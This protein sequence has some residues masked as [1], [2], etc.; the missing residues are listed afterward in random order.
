LNVDGAD[1]TEA[2]AE[3]SALIPGIRATLDAIPALAFALYP[4]GH[5]AFGNRA[6]LALTGMDRGADP[7]S[8]RTAVH[9]DDIDQG[10]DALRVGLSTQSSFR[11]R[12]RIRSA[13]GRYR[14]Y[15]S[16]ASPYLDAD[17][18]VVLWIGISTDVEEQAR[19]TFSLAESERRLRV[20]LESTPVILW[21]ADPSG[22][23]DWYNPHWYEFTGQTREEAAGW[24][25]QTAHH[26]DDF[27]EVM[28][29]WPHSIGTG[30]PFEMEFR[31]RRRDGIFRWMLTRIVPQRDDNGTIVR[32]YGSN[33][34][35][36]A[37]K[38]AQQRTTRLAE[39]LQ[40]A[41]LPDALPRGEAF[42]FDGVYRAAESESRV[43]G[44]WYD[45]AFL[46]DGRI[47][48]SIGDVT[49]H[50]IEAA[51]HA[52]RLRQAIT[53]A[54]LEDPNPASVLARV[55]RLVVT[56]KL[57]IA[58]AGVAIFDPTTMTV[59]YAL[60]G[61]PP[62]VIALA[63]GE[64]YLGA[65]GGLPLGVD[66]TFKTRE[67]VAHLPA[68]S[69]FAFYTDGI[70]EYAREIDRAERNL[71]EAA[72]TI[73]RQPLRHARVALAL[74]DAVLRGASNADDA[75]IIALQARGAFEGQAKATPDLL[76]TWRFHSSHAL[77]ARNAR[78]ELADY[79]R[80][81]ATEASATFEA[82]LVIGEIL[83]NTVR[84]A[85]GLVE[86]EID[87]RATRPRIHASD[88]GS[89]TATPVA[90][91]PSDPL[92]ESGRGLPLIFALATDVTIERDP[93]GGIAISC[94]L[95][96]ERH[97]LPAN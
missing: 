22:W 74:Y 37:Q 11:I 42:R 85:P 59:T 54:S 38:R 91:W 20:F 67:H 46:P 6:L 15:D 92:A 26:P 76:K 64:S 44:D 80:A 29:R 24:G 43:G 35:I 3:T 69:V 17:G 10:L 5:I 51:A 79:L 36:D 1:P 41:L 65:T 73:A 21:T 87:W 58:T 95:P 62:P 55:N 48:M 97:A 82:E 2:S 60:A 7:S 93:N 27:P 88:R 57:E 25:W 75:A 66:A 83:A 71:V 89:T 13:S 8:W 94:T 45:A 18:T 23:I 86:I 34:D 50:G 53:F 78:R 9:P 31:L 4:S 33:T 19:T 96:V 16:V 39:M 30:E 12:Q 81:Y 40:E 72:A 52:A 77:S 32:W 90:D 56:Q 68:D 70:T 28:R 47:T 49:G 14:Q 84:H 61:H 63:N